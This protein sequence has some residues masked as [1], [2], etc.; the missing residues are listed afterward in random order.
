MNVGQAPLASKEDDTNSG[1]RVSEKSEEQVSEERLG[2]DAN[3]HEYKQ[4]RQEKLQK[5][6]LR[7][8]ELGVP[9]L[10]A[11]LTTSATTCTRQATSV[12]NIGGTRK[13]N[14]LGYRNPKP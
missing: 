6:A 3:V 12:P 7:L 13:N 4:L 9:L 10:A 14:N 11:S 1:A 5:N 8:Q 2:R